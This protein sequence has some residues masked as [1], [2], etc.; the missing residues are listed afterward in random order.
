M[1]ECDTNM[2]INT[3]DEVRRECANFAIV[4]PCPASFHSSLQSLTYNL[5]EFK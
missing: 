2:A 1:P 3:A 4:S 5:K